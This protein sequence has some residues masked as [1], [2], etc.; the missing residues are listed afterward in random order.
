MCVLVTLLSSPLHHPCLVYPCFSYV[1]KTFVTF[2]LSRS[3]WTLH[4][5]GWPVYK[6]CV[7]CSKFWSFCH[8]DFCLL[9]C[10]LRLS[11]EN[12]ESDSSA[13]WSFYSLLRV[14][15]STLSLRR[16]GIKSLCGPDPWHVVLGSRILTHRLV[17]FKPYSTVMVHHIPHEFSTIMSEAS[18]HVSINEIHCIVCWTFI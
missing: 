10:F 17:A 9:A 8:K 7:P 5:F 6:D 15:I 2:Y 13:F 3:F 4:I 11:K 14:V 12:P 1:S 18:T 16:P